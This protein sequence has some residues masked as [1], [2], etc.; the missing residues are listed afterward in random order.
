MYELPTKQ[1]CGYVTNTTKLRVE[2]FTGKPKL[3]AAAKQ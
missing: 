1:C 2:M 3:Q